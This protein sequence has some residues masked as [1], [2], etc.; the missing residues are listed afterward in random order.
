VMS[1]SLYIGVAR[2]APGVVAARTGARIVMGRGGADAAAPVA[3]LAAMF[4]RAG[5]DCAVETDVL[6]AKWQKFLFNCGLNPLSAV[7]G[8]RLGAIMADAEGARLFTA[9]VD[10]AYRAGR[11][12]G[13]PIDEAA[14]EAVLALAARTDIGSSMAED[15]A[16]GRPLEAD[17]FAGTVQRLARRHGLATPAT[18][19]V[20]ALL[21][22]LDRG[23]QRQSSAT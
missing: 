9:L 11:A 10:E 5:I 16:A 18:D 14:R 4:A 7:A 1:G 23:R 2:T 17:A 15:L 8:V 22:L 19:S 20:A 21:G 3:A 12:A 13:A 6:R